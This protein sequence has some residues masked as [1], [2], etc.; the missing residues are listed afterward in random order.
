M[1]KAFTREDDDAGFELASRVPV[2]KGPITALGAR[3]AAEKAAAIRARLASKLEPSARA[4]LEVE[5]ARAEAFARASVAER[6]PHTDAVS[7]GAEVRFRDRIGRERVVLL[8]SADEIGLVPH[9]ASVTSP[10]ARALLGARPGDVVELDGPQG[11]ES[12]SVLEVRFP[13]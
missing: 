11:P 6:P 4:V 12:L 7:F 2:V 10:V 13:E 1:S 9:A 3:L 5:R 8:A